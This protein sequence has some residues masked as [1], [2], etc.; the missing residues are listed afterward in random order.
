MA[1]EATNEGEFVYAD[2]G[3]ASTTHLVGLASLGI[4]Y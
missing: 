1:V 3:I 2:A 4:P